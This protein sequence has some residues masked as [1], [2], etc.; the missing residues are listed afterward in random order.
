MNELY[1]SVALQTAF[2]IQPRLSQDL[3]LLGNG[4]NSVDVGHLYI[5]DESLPSGMSLLAGGEA[6]STVRARRR[7]FPRAIPAATIDAAI[8]D[9]AAVT[10]HVCHKTGNP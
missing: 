2:Q 3:P 6:V 7:R 8:V 10:A 4:L 5:M 1:R 9:G